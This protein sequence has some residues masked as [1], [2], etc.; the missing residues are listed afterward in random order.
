MLI[1]PVLVLASIGAVR[2][3][4]LIVMGL[5]LMIF[6]WRLA[7]GAT[8]W[9]ARLMVAG[10]LLLGFGY[11]VMLP[12]Y[13]AGIIERL[14]TGAPLDNPA[15]ALA[16]HAVKLVVMN[17]GWFVLGTGLA[18]HAGI[19]PSPAPRRATSRQ[20][21]AATRPQAPPV[22]AHESAA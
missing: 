5:C 22:P 11:S 10:S 3:V 2:P 6:I 17:S 15:T 1:P 21:Q 4:F 20:P 7:S 13:E 9:A 8:D 19:L 12:L 16:W 14:G 18:M